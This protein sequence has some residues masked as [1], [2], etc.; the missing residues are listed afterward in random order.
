M[1]RKIIYIFVLILALWSLIPVYW[2]LNLSFQ[3]RYQINTNPSYLVPPTPTVSG[4]LRALG[5]PAETPFGREEAS[6]YAKQFRVGLTNSFLVSIPVTVLTMAFA[7]PA[8]YVF[9]RTRFP[10]KNGLFFIILF[11]RTLPPVS[12][13]IP[14]YQLYRTIGLAGTQIG[15]I[16]SYLTLTLPLITWVL[17]GFFGTLPIEVER[18]AR[19]DGCSRGAAIRRV[20]LP[21][22]APGIA[23]SAVL[24]FLTSWNEFL[25]ALVLT[26]TTPA[27]TLPP[28]IAAPLF[29]F[30]SE[31]E[32]MSAI[33]SIA[34]VP[35]I[36]AAFVLQ[37]YIVR[38]RI[39]DPVTIRV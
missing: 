39:V 1:K 11:S 6:G 34:M 27:E 37:R 3:H 30:G 4:Y 9:G 35:A 21:I 25:F 18:A 28:T 15:L 2:L 8:G 32:V 17:T 29:G 23:A 16:V 24:T 14:Y 5:F 7:I 22:A 13:A 20:L 26:S 38:L 33:S 19:I 31:V 36:A 12:I 10:F